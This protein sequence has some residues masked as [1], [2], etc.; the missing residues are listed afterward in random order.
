MQT[1]RTPYHGR[2]GSVRCYSLLLLA[3]ASTA[4]WGQSAT[5]LYAEGNNAYEADKCVRAASRYYALQVRYPEWLT[6]QVNDGLNERIR[7]CEEHSAVYA[8]AKTDQVDTAA[9]PKP[10]GGLPGTLALP[11]NNRCDLYAE[12]AVTQYRVNRLDKCGFADSR[13]ND[14]LSRHH[15]WCMSVDNK[16]L[17]YENQARQQAL[18]ACHR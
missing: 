11:Q 1:Y 3:I 10:S 17:D 4:A 2:T 5:T 8:G 15:A 14:D 18:A 16:A 7:W 6:K 13:W 12:L 9:P